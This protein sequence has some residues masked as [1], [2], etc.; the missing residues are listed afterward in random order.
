MPGL[1]NIRYK[2]PSSRVL[3]QDAPAATQEHAVPRAAHAARHAILARPRA[4]GPLPE[5]PAAPAPS[6]R[7]ELGSSPSRRALPAILRRGR[8][9]AGR[10]SDARREAGAGAR[11]ARGS[12]FVGCL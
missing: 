11:G 6:A 4:S 5:R 3:A 8:C 1:R 9:R 7:E 12:A 2:S 10:R